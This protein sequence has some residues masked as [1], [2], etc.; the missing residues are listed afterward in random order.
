MRSSVLQDNEPLHFLLLFRGEIIIRTND[1]GIVDN[2]GIMFQLIGMPYISQRARE[3]P[4]TYSQLSSAGLFLLLTSDDACYFWIGREYYQKVVEPE[5]AA[6]REAAKKI[7][8]QVDLGL[9]H[10]LSYKLFQR[11]VATITNFTIDMDYLKV[12]ILLEGGETASFL[13]Y[14]QAVPSKRDIDEEPDD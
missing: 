12:N 3:I 13:E 6:A 14:M 8:K 7:N 10:L 9:E 5:L 2:D 11:I 4:V 1:Y